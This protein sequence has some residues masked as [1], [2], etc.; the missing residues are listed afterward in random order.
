M[1]QDFSSLT[2]THK[3]LCI[4]IH[5]FHLLHSYPFIYTYPL[6]FMISHVKYTWTKNDV[7]YLQSF[8]NTYLALTLLFHLILT[9]MNW[10]QPR[11]GGLHFILNDNINHNF[12]V[13]IG[14]CKFVG[15]V[16]DVIDCG[17]LDMYFVLELRKKRKTHS[18]LT[19]IL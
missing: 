7:I 1:F 4:L 14:H 18:I 11:K 2:H 17:C 5:Q 12:D 19:F 16:N 10:L 13:K 15:F 9:R 8:D 3:T 6:P